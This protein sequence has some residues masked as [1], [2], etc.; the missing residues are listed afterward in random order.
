MLFLNRKGSRTALPYS[1]KCQLIS[2]EGVMERENGHGS[3]TTATTLPR[4]PT[5]RGRTRAT[6]STADLPSFRGPERRP[7]WKQD[8]WWASLARRGSSDDKGFGKNV[9]NESTVWR[10]ARVCVV[11]GSVLRPKCF[12]ARHETLT[13]EGGA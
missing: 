2:E 5:S 4:T 8:R 11:W 9:I 7:C 1:I 12:Q 6:G 3:S 13:R 10:E